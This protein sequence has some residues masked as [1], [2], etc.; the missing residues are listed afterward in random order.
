MEIICKKC[1]RKFTP[2][3]KNHIYNGSESILHGNESILNGSENIY[4][5]NEIKIKD[6]SC[7]FCGEKYN[8]GKIKN[9]IKK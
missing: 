7:P 3:F 1:G 2:I 6:F 8:N 9:N 5:G 4:N